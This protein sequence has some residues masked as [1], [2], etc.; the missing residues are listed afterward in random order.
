M[1]A[2]SPTNVTL[3]ACLSGIVFNIGIIVNAYPTANAN[4]TANTS[5]EI[6]SQ[7]SRNPIAAPQIPSPMLLHPIKHLRACFAVSLRRPPLLPPSPSLSFTRTGSEKTS[8]RRRRR[9]VAG[10]RGCPRIFASEE[11][12]VYIWRPFLGSDT[13]AGVIAFVIVWYV[14]VLM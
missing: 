14:A 9:S 8:C 2:V 13:T 1:L 7:P 5:V 10:R 3:A 6:M 4:P 11:Y 12:T